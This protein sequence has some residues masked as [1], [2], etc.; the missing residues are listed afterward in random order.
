V[1]DNSHAFLGG[2]RLWE[3]AQKTKGE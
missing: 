3:N 1:G 2:I